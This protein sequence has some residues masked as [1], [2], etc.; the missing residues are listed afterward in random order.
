MSG[1]AHWFSQLWRYGVVGVASNGLLFGVYLLLT[2]F[3]T[4]PL[5]AMTALYALGV[6]QTFVFN[7]RWTF[8][9]RTSAPQAFLRYVLSYGMGYL[10]NLALLLGLHHQLGLP[11]AWVQALAIIATALLLFLLQRYWVFR[12]SPAGTPQT[13]SPDR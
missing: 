4:P 13:W 9:S 2:H 3:G 11:H 12:A 6:L 10:F 1:R 5:L 8:A 7:R